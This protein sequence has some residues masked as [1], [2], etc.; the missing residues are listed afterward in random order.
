MKCHVAMLMLVSLA[1][2]GCP[3]KQEGPQASQLPPP[4]KPA[5][6]LKPMEGPTNLTDMGG[7]EETPSVPAAGKP[8][9]TV[10][11]PPAPSAPPSGTRTYTVVKGDGLMSIARKQLGD[12]KRWREIQTL[13]PTLTDPNKLKVGQVIIL[14]AK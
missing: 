4:P 6:E 14:P 7:L 11:A 8:A 3:K 5:D 2:F 9:G 10:T 12:A 1:I 13:N